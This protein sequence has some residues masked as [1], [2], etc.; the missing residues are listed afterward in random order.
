MKIRIRFTKLGDLKYIG[1]LDVMRYF[2]KALRRAGIDMTY[3]QGFNPHPIM[4]FASPLGL[5]YTS[6]G[7]YFDVELNSAVSSEDIMNRLNAVMTEGFNIISVRKIPDDSKMN[8][9]ASLYAACYEIKTTDA[10][11]IDELKFSEFF[12]QNDIVIH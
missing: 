7:E 6:V 2:Q 10:L 1:H 11:N 5:G 9:M 4:S 3:S 8:A 12:N